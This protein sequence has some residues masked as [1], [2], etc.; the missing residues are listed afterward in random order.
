M[1]RPS[2]G[3][4]WAGALWAAASC[5][6]P[7][8][9]A[10]VPE[11]EDPLYVGAARVDI[12]PD[13][14]TFE[15]RNGNGRRDP[16]EPFRDLNGNGRWDP[17]YLAGFGL[18]RTA[19]GV[20][21]ALWARAVWFEKG[22]RR[23]VLVAFDLVGLPHGRVRRLRARLGDAGDTAIL[24]A[25]HVHS[26]P[27]TSG[28]WG[29]LPGLSGVSEPYLGR[30]EEAVADVV[31]RA[32]AGRRPARLRAV[33]ARVEG[34]VKDIRPPAVKNETA[35]AILAEDVSGH[36]LA[37]VAS[38]AM[39]PEALGAK[40]RFITSDYPHFLREA[41]ERDF[42]GA[43]AVFTAADLG[44]MQT[45]DVRE[46]TWEEARRVGEAVA[47]RVTEA[48]REAP[49]VPVPELRFRRREVRFAVE[50]RRFLAAFKAGVFGREAEPLMEEREG[51]WTV[52]SEVAALRL[53]EILLVTVPG[54]AFPEVGREVFAPVGARHKMLVGLGQDEVGYILPKADFDPNRYEE[55]M[56]LG[57]E[58]AP[59]LLGALKELL[60][61]F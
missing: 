36:P 15:D 25:T 4:L 21:D 39:H 17:V 60:R 59:T 46:A 47:G 20:R 61:D 33:S 5:A 6:W 52:L 38:F 44:G 24:C 28:L 16:D 53:G 55:S 1:R 29:P 26:G 19:L 35:A 18:N 57:P 43:V 54:E 42:P 41:L 7:A 10:G 3:S 22:K 40:N 51:R 8:P 31:G 30:L 49:T 12:T 48:L 23:A 34:V 9:P 45:P 11:T 27:D 58:T 50:N 32:R 56:S 14:E 2:S 13:V 37:V